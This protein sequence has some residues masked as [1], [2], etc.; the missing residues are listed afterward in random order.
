MINASNCL[1]QSVSRQYR[2]D[3]YHKALKY[4]TVSAEIYMKLFIIT[5]LSFL[6]SAC[7]AKKLAVE[8]A[9]TLLS[10]QI[11]KRVPLYSKQKDKLNKEIDQFLNEKK[12]VAQEILPVL[13]NLD[14]EDSEKIESQYK[15]LENFFL[16][17]SSDF[18]ALMS[19]QI[20]RMD[21]KQQKDFFET[22][23][24]ENREILKKE[25]E[26]RIDQF[27]E[28]F[29]SFFGSIMGPQKQ[30]VREY[31]NYFD[32]RARERLDR[33]VKLHQKFRDIMAQEVSTESKEKM[34]QEAFVDYQQ[35]VQKGSRNLEIIKKLL[36]TVTDI[37]RE[38][39]RGQVQE[40]KDLLK[41]YVSLDY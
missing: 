7:A 4:A 39:F 22:L 11:T 15:K 14:I 19:R 36:P 35:E 24:D 16:N 10:H 28:R 5:V 8:N 23:D 29:E 41:Y 32:S 34:I 12:E 1:R 38:H 13:D 37:Q 18:S 9:D 33:R 3:H 20:A 31:A 27:E 26:D 2:P 40:I 21:K 30:I 6:L 25:K 17:I